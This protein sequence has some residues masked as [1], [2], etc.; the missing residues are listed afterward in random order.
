[1]V[2]TARLQAEGRLSAPCV[3]AVAVTDPQGVYSTRYSQNLLAPDGVLVHTIPFALNDAA[4]DWTVEAKDVATGTS[5]RV[6]LRRE[7]HTVRPKLI[8]DLLINPG[9]GFMTF[10][11]FN[12]DA[13][14]PGTES[15]TEG[16]PIEYQPA[17]D[18]LHNPDYPDTSLAYFRVYWSYLEPERGAYR[19]EM[20]D[21]ALA[22]A[23]SR[24]QTLLLRIAPH[25]FDRKEDVPAW[26]RAMVG[27]KRDF[28][29]PKW[30]VDPNDERYAQCFG[31]MIRA[32][33][34]RYDGHPGLESVD[35]ALMSA[36]GESENA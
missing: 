17:P 14:N 19:W 22:T 16:H 30:Q 24:G 35:M 13:L 21:K 15:W 1:P 12:G 20:I 33:G 27:P 11:R 2:L 29:E 31:G 7:G 9:M 10:Q 26:Y 25:G 28:V 6:L 18:T 34:R 23:Q 3:F 5:A 8:D 32:L 36:W 4:G